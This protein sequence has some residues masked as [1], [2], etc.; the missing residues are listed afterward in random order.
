[1]YDIYS[2][3]DSYLLIDDV[4][5]K[6]FIFVRTDAIHVSATAV[7]PQLHNLSL[8]RNCDAS[9]VAATSREARISLSDEMWLADDA[10]DDDDDDVAECETDERKAAVRRADVIP[11]PASATDAPSLR[12]APTARRD[13]AAAGVGS[14]TTATTDRGD[15]DRCNPTTVVFD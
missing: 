8:H 2:V 12:Q 15:S 4:R 14:A 9:D 10:G 5:K 13:A 6:Q 11:A 7:T 1:M 3:R